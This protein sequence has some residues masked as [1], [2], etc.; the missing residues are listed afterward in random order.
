MDASFPP[1]WPV[2]VEVGMAG[3]R[4]RAGKQIERGCGGSERIAELREGTEYKEWASLAAGNVEDRLLHRLDARGAFGDDENGEVWN[5]ELGAEGLAR[6]D[7]AIC[8]HLLQE[9]GGLER[10]GSH[11]VF[12]L[13]FERKEA[14]A[15]RTIAFGVR[16]AEER[17]PA[18]GRRQ[19]FPFCRC[20]G[21]CARSRLA[22]RADFPAL[23]PLELRRLFRP[24]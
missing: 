9:A 12:A 8:E 22:A 13:H 5:A 16:Q 24:R 23:P 10:R 20:A 11:P 3:A 7:I 2:D 17:R 14:E 1:L 4:P 19:P 18:P 21:T 6:G 15:L